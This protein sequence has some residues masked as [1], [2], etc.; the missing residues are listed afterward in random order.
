MLAQQIERGQRSTARKLAM[1][2]SEPWGKDISPLGRLH[3]VTDKSRPPDVGKPSQLMAIRSIEN[4]SSI[5]T[6]VDSPLQQK[7]DRITA[8]NFVNICQCL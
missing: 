8:G 6:E 4:G 1:V 3:T 2:K 5:K 7:V